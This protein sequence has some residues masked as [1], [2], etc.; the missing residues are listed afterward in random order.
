MMTCAGYYHVYEWPLTGFGL[1]IGFIEHLQI[2]TT[3]NNSAITNPHSVV[4][5]SM[6]QVFS[7][8]CWVHRLAAIS[9]QH[10]TLLTAILKSKL[11]YDRWSAGQSVLMSRTHLGL[12]TR[13][14]LLSD[15][16]RFVDVGRSSLR[17]NRSAIYNCCL[18]SPA[19]SF[20]G[21][22]PAGLVTIFYCLRFET[23]PT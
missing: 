4:H 2:I 3:S 5:Y 21:P 1:V 14:L 22:S 16:C 17:Q 23:R 8:C 19:Q 12:M 10:P 20:F 11:C 13:F 6:Y 18:S 7:V 9:H 15:S